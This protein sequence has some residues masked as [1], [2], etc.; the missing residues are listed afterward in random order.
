M[1]VD[2]A[3][4][5]LGPDLQRSAVEPADPEPDGG[6]LVSARSSGAALR[7]VDCSPVIKV[8]L[9]A[10]P[11][12]ALAEYLEVPFGRAELFEDGFLVV[13]T[14]PGAWL[15]LCP[16]DPR[17][18]LEGLRKIDPAHPPG[19]VDVTHGHTLVR[20]TGADAASVMGPLTAL[21]LS[22]R[23]LPTGA[24]TSAA[25]AGVRVTI[26][27]DDLFADEAGLAPP[28][29]SPTAPDAAVVGDA[30]GAVGAA[31]TEL[32]AGSGS[33]PAEGP[34]VP[35][36]LLCC[37]R[38]AGRYLYERLLEAGLPHGLGEEGYLPYRARRPDV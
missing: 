3:A 12:G 25:V 19:I 18:L 28:A 10:P 30:P 17:E 15:L 27:R 8:L 36:Y 6:W 13:C 7:V 31:T 34:D 32:P 1:A 24:A 21:D 11:A 5:T 37:D 38:S 20:L 2:L 4:E 9:Q 16:G 26:V 23:T 33:E 14:A 35:S 29:S 22:D